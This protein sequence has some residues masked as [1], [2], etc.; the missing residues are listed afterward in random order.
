MH[1]LISVTQRG[2]DIFEPVR[3]A[4][5]T[6]VGQ[7]IV[8]GVRKAGAVLKNNPYSLVLSELIFPKSFGDGTLDAHN[9]RGDLGGLKMYG[10]YD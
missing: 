10:P 2:P 7:E 4:I 1:N 5:G 9:F 3:Q 6:P 8:G